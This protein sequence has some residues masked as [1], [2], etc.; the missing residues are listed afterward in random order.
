MAD[1]TIKSRARG[2]RLPG[3]EGEACGLNLF[4]GLGNKLLLEN[5]PWRPSFI[6]SIRAS[7]KIVEAA[8]SKG[9]E[10]K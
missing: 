7:N 10:F 6:Q 1:L 3:P 5:R 8:N 9:K 2:I 4:N